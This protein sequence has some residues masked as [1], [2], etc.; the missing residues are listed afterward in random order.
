MHTASFCCDLS[1]VVGPMAAGEMGRPVSARAL[2]SSSEGA[3]LAPQEGAGPLQA[4]RAR[5]NLESRSEAS[6]PVARAP[7]F[8]S[9]GLDCGR[10][11]LPWLQ[12]SLLWSLA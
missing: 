7:L 5:E 12:S 2:Q 10:V 1:L 9:W 3:A 4:Q 8:P 6:I 11:D